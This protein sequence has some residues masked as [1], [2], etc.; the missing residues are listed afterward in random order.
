[1]RGT[2][3]FAGAQGGTQG[4]I[5]AYAGNTV[6]VVMTLRSHWDHPRICG[7]HPLV[8]GISR[9][10]RGSS[11][12]M[13]GTRMSTRSLT[14]KHGII[15][16]YAGNTHPTRN[17]LPC[18]RDHP[19]ICGEH[20]SVDAFRVSAAVCCFR[21][22][23]RICGEHVRSTVSAFGSGGSSPHMR[24]TRPI[25]KGRGTRPGIIPAY[26]GNTTNDYDFDTPRRDHPRICG[27]HPCGIPSVDRRLGSS[28]HMR[29]THTSKSNNLPAHGII[30]AYAGNTSSLL[31]HLP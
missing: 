17:P 10:A 12:H 8:H 19:R 21:D 25:R 15:P 27:E 14:I 3:K 5:P 6:T 11:P 23:P 26:A 7:E 30:P 24:G 4:I 31:Q 29:G 16:A 20:F 1:M 2:P 28:P 13:R 18:R 22:H 9:V